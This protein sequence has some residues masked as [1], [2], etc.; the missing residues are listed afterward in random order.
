MNKIIFI[1]TGFILILSIVGCRE[2]AFNPSEN[3]IINTQKFS[4]DYMALRLDTAKV[5]R[6]VLPSSEKIEDSLTQH[7]KLWNNRNYLNVSFFGGNVIIQNKILNYANQW[8][9]H[10]GITFRSIKTD[11]DIR[12]SFDEKSGS[13]SY[14]GT[15]ALLIDKDK[16]T[17]NYSWVSDQTPEEEVK[18]IVLHEFGHVLGLPHEQ[19]RSDKKINWKRQNVYLYYSSYP[20]YWTSQQ[21]DAYILNSVRNTQMIYDPNDLK[22]IMQYPISTALTN[23]TG[24]SKT[25]SN[26][27]ANDKELISFVYPTSKSEAKLQPINMK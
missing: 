19:Q 7:N 20:N 16:P 13:W 21:V 4:A 6:L 10:T 1:F 5:C 25:N 17:M 24:I 12:I 26:L 22:S 9:P 23:E 3:S 11:G 27:S 8:A 15:D 18:K 2:E 14:I